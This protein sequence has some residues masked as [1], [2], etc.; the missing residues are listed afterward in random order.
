[1]SRDSVIDERTRTL[2]FDSLEAFLTA[3]PGVGVVALAEELGRPV[4]GIDLVRVMLT[5]AYGRGSQAFREAA[6]D[7]LARHLREI[8]IN[9]WGRLRPDDTPDTDIEIVN[10]APWSIWSS[11]ISIVDKAA[12]ERTS[13]VFDALNATAE[14]GWK[15][16]D[17]NDPALRRAFD[18][19]W[20]VT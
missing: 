8:Q 14:T 13:A 2:G 18:S 5:R 12:S 17:K 16:A 4:I 9:G 19:G 20:P 6:I 1:M 15:P 11:Q 3:R 7:L 10:I